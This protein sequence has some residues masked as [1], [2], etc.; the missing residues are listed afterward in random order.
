M[1]FSPITLARKCLRLLFQ[2]LLRFLRNWT[3][4]DSKSLTQ[5]VAADVTRSRL[6]LILENAFLRQQMIILSRQPKR[7]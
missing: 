2:P 1:H 6:D 7:L 4:P 3:R 5:S